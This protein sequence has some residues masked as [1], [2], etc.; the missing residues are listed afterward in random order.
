[1]F[2]INELKANIEK[3]PSGEFSELVRWLL[4]Q[5]WKGWDQEI[6]ADAPDGRPNS[7]GCEAREERAGETEM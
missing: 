4:E 2:N 7:L 6:G 3:L 1:M 5:D